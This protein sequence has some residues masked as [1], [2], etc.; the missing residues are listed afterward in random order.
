MLLDRVAAN[1]EAFIK[2]Y[3]AACTECP[4]TAS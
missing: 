2:R 3:N 4:T 1:M